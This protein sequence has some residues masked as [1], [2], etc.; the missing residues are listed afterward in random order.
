MESGLRIILVHF[1]GPPSPK[2]SRNHSPA[3]DRLCARDTQN[4]FPLIGT[5]LA[6][7]IVPTWASQPLGTLSF[8]STGTSLVSSSPQSFFF[9]GRRRSVSLPGFRITLTP[10]LTALSHQPPVSR[11]IACPLHTPP[12][13][14]AFGSP[15]LSLSQSF[16]HPKLRHPQIFL[17]T[18]SGYTLPIFPLKLQSS[19]SLPS[20]SPITVFSL[21]PL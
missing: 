12:I 18:L 4:T 10:Q 5:L 16:A 21:E 3:S 20:S 6:P 11:P 7:T 17:F 15:P 9:S 8:P 1:H 2:V 13:S 14:T 19:F